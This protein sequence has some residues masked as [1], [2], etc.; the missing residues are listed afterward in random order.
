MSLARTNIFKHLSYQTL[1]IIYTKYKMGWG[2]IGVTGNIHISINVRNSK[3]IP[4][5]RT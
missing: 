5:G 2:L 1:V 4:C 3:I